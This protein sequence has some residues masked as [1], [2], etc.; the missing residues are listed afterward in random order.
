M[1]KTKQSLQTI[2]RMLF[3]QCTEMIKP[4][5]NRGLPPNLVAGEPS[6]S[7]IWKGTD[8]MLLA[9][10]QVELGF[11]A[12]PVGSHVQTAEMGNQAINSLALISGRYTL[13]AVQTLSQLSAAHLVAA[14]QALVAA[15]QARNIRAI[16]LR[17]AKTLTPVFN[18]MVDEH[19]RNS[20]QCKKTLDALQASMW[21]A[22][23][24]ALDG[25]TSLDSNKT[26]AAATKS[27]QSVAL[28]NLVPST[29]LMVAIC[30]WTKEYTLIL[31]EIYLMS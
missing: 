25:L 14:C 21:P 19:F 12:N 4:A 7:F 31:L 15:C 9:T 13:D 18:K 2:G 10:L 8:S 6:E 29:K 27:L 24:K 26:F 28:K 11:V 1:E 23:L 17:F 22:F 16:N 5:T 30:S 20:M 3:A